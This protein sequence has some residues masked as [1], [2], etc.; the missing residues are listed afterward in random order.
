MGG[1]IELT[2]AFNSKVARHF[3][4]SLRDHGMRMFKEERGNSSQGNH[5]II[6]RGSMFVLPG[7]FFLGNEIKIPKT[8]SGI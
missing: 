4:V 1:S 6:D 7:E 3:V 8:L 5:F 2:S